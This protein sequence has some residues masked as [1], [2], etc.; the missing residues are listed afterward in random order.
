MRMMLGWA[1]FGASSAYSA[2]S[3]ASSRAV[4]GYKTD[5]T[6]VLS[7]GAATRADPVVAF[8]GDVR[9]IRTS[10]IH[11]LWNTAKGEKFRFQ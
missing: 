5:F 1:G 11:I 7:W 9:Q 3:G 4:R 10:L 8:G 2:V 6:T